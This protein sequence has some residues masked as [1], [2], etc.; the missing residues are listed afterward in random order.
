[1]L[2]H[3]VLPDNILL[4]TLTPNPKWTKKCFTVITNYR[5][6]ALSSVL[7]YWIQ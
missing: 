1:M 3:G 6:I 2:K 4:A 7:S 5:V